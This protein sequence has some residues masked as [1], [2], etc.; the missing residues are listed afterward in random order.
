M[1]RRVIQNNLRSFHRR[2]RGWGLMATAI[3]LSQGKCE[4]LDILSS[5]QHSFEEDLL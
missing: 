5:L 3:L 4:N 1:K 2:R